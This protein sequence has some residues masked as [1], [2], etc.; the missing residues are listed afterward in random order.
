M[1]KVLD[2][3]KILKDSGLTQVKDI[4]WWTQR[5]TIANSNQLIVTWHVYSS[6]QYQL[7]NGDG[8]MEKQARSLICKGDTISSAP[9]D[10]M[11]GVQGA[12]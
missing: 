4:K 5:P 8:V 7:Q 11:W 12:S 1:T 10:S 2:N 6:D 3:K 9:D